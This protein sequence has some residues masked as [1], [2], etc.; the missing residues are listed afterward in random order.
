[1]TSND[2]GLMRRWKES[3][4]LNSQKPTSFFQYIHNLSFESG[5]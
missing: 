1:M 4:L 2:S 3:A 5:K